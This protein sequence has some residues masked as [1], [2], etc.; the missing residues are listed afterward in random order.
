M[1]FEQAF[2]RTQ[3]RHLGLIDALIA[4]TDRIIENNTLIITQNNNILNNINNNIN[5]LIQQSIFNNQ[6][7]NSIFRQQ[8][9]NHNRNL[10]RNNNVSPNIIPN[11]TNRENNDNDA[12]INIDDTININDTNNIIND[13]RDNNNDLTNDFINNTTQNLLN[14]ILTPRTNT[15][16]QNNNNIISRQI[17][18]LEP[19]TLQRT[20]FNTILPSI[21]DIID[22]I[23]IPNS[24][25]PINIPT[26]NQ[27]NN[28]TTE[29]L[30]QYL[31]NPLNTTCAIRH[32]SFQPDDI[33]LK[34]N[35]CG[36]IF[37]KSELLE[38]FTR[39]ARCPLCRYNILNNRDGATRSTDDNSNTTYFR[40][41]T[42]NT[43]NNDISNS[44][45]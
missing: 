15:F 2:Y 27:I 4:T 1:N 30:Y 12:N 33:V 8:Y 25:P 41:I 39:S 37:Y 22:N 5:D 35:H 3:N 17:Y 14:S 38:W 28:S 20:D 18:N 43:H 42:R 31:E 6:Q 21:N 11:N 34:I 45:R 29:T 40:I 24:P 16:R 13:Y 10:N 19:L 36:H 23:I 44:S 7:I 32:V 9:N 26:L